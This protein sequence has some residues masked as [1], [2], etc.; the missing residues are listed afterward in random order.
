MELV[1]D[2]EGRDCIR[3]QPEPVIADDKIEAGAGKDRGKIPALIGNCPE[4]ER[5]KRDKPWQ[6]EAGVAVR[7]RIIGEIDGRAVGKLLHER[8]TGIAG[9][10][11]GDLV[12]FRK[13]F[14]DEGDIPGCMTQTPVQRR[15]QYACHPL[16]RYCID[17]AGRV[18]E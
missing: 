13:E 18:F 9:C 11:N 6:E 7:D 15:N 2:E 17:L 10:G 8:G 5:E 14:L 3:V 16:L 12:T 1:G 4:H